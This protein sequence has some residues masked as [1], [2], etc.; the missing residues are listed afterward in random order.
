MIDKETIFQVLCG[1]M[2]HP[3]Y[4][5]SADKYNLSPDDF[6]TLFERYIYA[7]IFNLYRSG[8]E[9]I[10]VVDIDNYFNLHP[11][12][13]KIFEQNNGIEVLQ[14]NLDI[15]QVDN[16]NFYYQRLK[17]LNILKDLKNI[18]YIHFFKSIIDFFSFRIA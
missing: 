8:A 12:A 5:A 3:Q 15:V 10:T 18:F 13:K 17:K 16:F 9:R 7:A 2:E 11:E 1:L 14:D 6:T 4:L